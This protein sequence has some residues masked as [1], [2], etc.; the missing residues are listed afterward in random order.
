[1]LF[2]ANLKSVGLADTL[3]IGAS[4]KHYVSTHNDAVL[5]GSKQSSKTYNHCGLKQERF[6]S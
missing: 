4:D 6:N 2:T 3:D 1:M 5:Q